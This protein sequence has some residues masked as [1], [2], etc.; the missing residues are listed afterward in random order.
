MNILIMRG[1][2][3]SSIRYFIIFAVSLWLTPFVDTE[4]LSAQLKPV[5]E[6]AASATSK[7]EE[8]KKKLKQAAIPEDKFGRGTPRNTVDGFLEAARNQ[9]FKR[10]AEYLDLRRLTPSRQKSQGPKLARELKIVFDQALLMDLDILSTD[11]KGHLDDSLPSYRDWV[12]RIDAKSRP[13]SIFLQRVPRQDGTQIWKFASTTVAKVPQLYEE[14]GY[15]WF[16]DILPA[17]FFDIEVLGLQAWWWVALVVLGVLAYFAAILLA[18]FLVF[19]L[20]YVKGPLGDQLLPIVT[21]PGR[22][23]I[24]VF[25]W[26][27]WVELMGPSVALQQMMKGG[28]LLIIAFVWTAM[29]LCDVLLDQ[30]GNRLR[31]SGQASATVLLRPIGNAM[32]VVLILIGVIIWLDNIQYNVTALLAGLG[33][34]GIAVALAAQKSI[35]HLIGAITLYTAQ[36]VRV[37]DF[38]RFGSSLGTVEEIG[39]RSTRIR[40][41]DDTLVSVPNAEF[42][43]LHL[44]NYSK[45]QKIWYH[46]RLQLRYETTPDQLRYVLVEI[47]KLLYSHPRVY[48]DPARVRFVGFG[49]YSLDLDIFA[50]IAETDYGKFLE[51]SE[52]LNLRIMDIVREAGSSFA[53]PAQTTYLERGKGLDDGLAREAESKVKEW[54]E[55]KALYL[56]EF[57]PEK[58]GELR[59][60]LDYPPPGSPSSNR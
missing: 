20:H 14:F 18:K 56:P 53:V 44:D 42:S 40:T 5:P 45:R 30:L 7:E 46:P 55:Q 23:L 13:V 57:P 28:V 33:V 43:N 15:G 26:K 3:T 31:R 48:P 38:C 1:V 8:I 41:L 32:R 39:L 24:F 51:V 35:E 27:A 47:R 2:P 36:P 11:P 49:D 9:D 22:F 50:Y 37:G 29:R 17:V 52:D 16:G 59:G 58:I 6:K 54:R 10:A 25:L 4:S 21:G 60:S 34:G 19:A 12:G